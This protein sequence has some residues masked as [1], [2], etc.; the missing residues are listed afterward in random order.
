M[1]HIITVDIV[2]L[3][4]KDPIVHRHVYF[5]KLNWSQFH[6]TIL[7]KKSF[8]NSDLINTTS[9]GFGIFLHSLLPS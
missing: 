2:A 6:P 1:Q 9:K 3:V 5:A 8:R 4:N 7:K